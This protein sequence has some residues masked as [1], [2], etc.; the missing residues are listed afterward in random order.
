LKPCSMRYTG[1]PRPIPGDSSTRSMNK[2]HRRDVLERASELVRR[3]RAA[4]G[5]DRLT[6]QQVE[7]YGVDRLLDQLAAALKDGGNR[8]LP[9]EILEQPRGGWG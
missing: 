7:R 6:I 5:I 3:N 2:V 9:A 8:P 4:P 1:R